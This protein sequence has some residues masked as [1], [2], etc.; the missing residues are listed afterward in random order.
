MGRAILR[1]AADPG[2][3]ERARAAAAVHRGAAARTAHQLV[4][5]YDTRYPTGRRAQPAWMFLW[6]LSQLWR[7]GSALDR[8]RKRKRVRM[9]PVPVVSVGN[10]TAGGTGKTPV[11]IELLRDFQAQSPAL[12]TRGHGRSTSHVVLLPKG[13]ERLPVG[14]TGDEAQL[15]VRSVGVPI[16]IGGERFHA[17]T[18]LLAEAAVNVFFMDD[19]FQHMQLA[20]DFNLVLIDS[21]DPFGGGHLL[22]LGRLREPLEGL[23]RADAFLITRARDAVALKAIESVLRFWNPIAPVFRAHTVARSWRNEAG[24]RIDAHSIPKLRSIAFC[25]LGNPEA[26][27]NTLTQLGVTLVERYEYGDHHRYKPS[28]IRR[29]AQ[30]GHDLGIEALLTTSKDSVNLCPETESM[31]RPLKLYWLEIGIDIERHED[32]LSLISSRIFHEN[33]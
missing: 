18:K 9:L 29:L 20:R 2:F 26:F 32:L 23:T 7:A 30:R 33:I 5:L 15:Y 28:E 10:I 6:L 16:G 22:P 1:A 21:L 11:T 14:L 3:G 12:L 17:G 13:T 25:G 31:I 27:W 4:S 24:E 8:R 19:G